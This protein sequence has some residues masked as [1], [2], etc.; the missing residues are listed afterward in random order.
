MNARPTGQ[1]CLALAKGRD[2]A[3]PKAQASCPV[4]EGAS[5]ART[6]EH[7]KNPE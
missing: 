5:A 1:R 7:L 4:S 2:L 3:Q 6:A